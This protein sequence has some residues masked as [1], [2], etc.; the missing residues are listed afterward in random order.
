MRIAI[1]F[2]GRSYEHE[3]SIVS[4]IT[5]K[6]ILDNPL[7]IFLDEKHEFYLIDDKKL[8][9]DYFSNGEYKSS[10]KLEI[11]HQGFKHK[12][13]LKTEVFLDLKVINLIHGADG[14]D[15]TINSLFKFFDIPIISPSTEASVISF[16]KKLTKLFAESVSVSV[17]PFE[18]LSIFDQEKRTNLNFPIII[19]PLR[20]GSSIGIQVVHSQDTFQYALDSAFE[21]DDEVII[22]PYFSNIRE[23]NIAG[24]LTTNELVISNIE[25]VSKD[26]KRASEIL[27]FEAK[28]LDFSRNEVIQN[29][30][31]SQEIKQ[32]LIENFKKL[33]SPMFHGSVI[34]CDFFLIDNKIY[35]NEINSVPGSLA[36]YLFEDFQNILET[37]KPVNNTLPTI[38]YQYIQQI[39]K[40]K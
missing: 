3:I 28:Y 17:L 30:E 21:F 5:L 14:E 8:R 40:S 10:K 13:F 29:S 15:G 12:T 34:R 18:T 27:D 23:F 22:E 33:Y 2:G 9:A 16:N 37:S 7:F 38:S 26:K 4:A 25:E 31:I 24:V 35:L 1:L 19:K 6:N 11:I 20:L 32:E 36:N 39:K